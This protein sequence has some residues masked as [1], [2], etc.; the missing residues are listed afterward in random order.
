MVTAA[1]TAV[2]HSHRG[3][4]ALGKDGSR[5]RS[6]R[7]MMVSTAYALARKGCDNFRALRAKIV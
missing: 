2:A 3:R 5:S 7:V 6:S 1:Q 4:A